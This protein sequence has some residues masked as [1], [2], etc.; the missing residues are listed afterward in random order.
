M[1][2]NKYLNKNINS[3][4]YK[5]III[6]IIIKDQAPSLTCPGSSITV[7]PSSCNVVAPTLATTM[8]FTTCLNQIAS[9]SSISTN[10]ATFST[11]II[12]Q[13]QIYILIWIKVV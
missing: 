9:I 3:L 2:S 4:K 5:K 11:P 8:L 12:I 1:W 6:F 13:G 10:N 7:S